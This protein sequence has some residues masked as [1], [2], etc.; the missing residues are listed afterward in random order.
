MMKIVVMWIGPLL[1]ATL[2]TTSLSK[3]DPHRRKPTYAHSIISGAGAMTLKAEDPPLVLTTLN[4][5][6]GEVRNG[7]LR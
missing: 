4:E 1:L 2:L 5:R 6:V 7:E 3:W